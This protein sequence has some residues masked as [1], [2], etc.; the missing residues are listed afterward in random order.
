MT[1]NTIRTV[2]V[3]TLMIICGCSAQLNT[4]T[5]KSPTPKGTDSDLAK[6]EAFAPADA[7][8]LLVL[9]PKQLKEYKPLQASGFDLST[10]LP[11]DVAGIEL[12]A[13][14]SSQESIQ[15]VW[16]APMA[17]LFERMEAQLE[18][19]APKNLPTVA[20]YMNKDFSA[21]IKFSKPTKIE[22]LEKLLEHYGE[23]GRAE[24]YARASHGEMD[25]LDGGP[26]R[27]SVVMLDPQTF[28]IDSRQSLKDA[29]N[30][31]LNPKRPANVWLR[32][33]V[34]SDFRG[35]L[36]LAADVSK[37]EKTDG[38]GM[39][40]FATS[41]LGNV[42]E[43]Q[44]KLSLNQSMLASVELGFEEDQLAAAFL[45]YAET[46]IQQFLD[47]Q[48]QILASAPT[49]EG[50]DF[51]LWR[52][53]QAAQLSESLS[54]VRLGDRVTMKLPRPK[55]LDQQ[56]TEMYKK[57]KKL[58]EEMDRNQQRY[59]ATM[60]E[61]VIWRKRKQPGEVVQT[62]DCAT[63][64]WP[65]ELIPEGAASN[66]EAVIGQR[67]RK[68]VS[69]GLPVMISDFQSHAKSKS[70]NNRPKSLT[71]MKAHVEPGAE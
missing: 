30:S 64:K 4:V 21:L 11:I 48:K 20:H 49:Y 56:I 28:V 26:D 67:L 13:V 61:V 27:C 63:E 31:Q 62:G 50:A 12:I 17:T 71:V 47:G 45:S 3:A 41:S 10:L 36:F 25:I 34:G 37:I 54:I 5:L 65:A 70:R 38:I 24:A 33:L 16:R 44:V 18:K 35:E 43:L 53:R 52:A 40:G 68:R 9:R 23:K 55:H 14:A 2:L 57:Q 19:R 58:I 39:T 29:L 6:F 15:K 1:Y 8:V 42:Q 51:D 32:D 69:T 66:A 60:K 22:V 46:S 59:Q 7:E